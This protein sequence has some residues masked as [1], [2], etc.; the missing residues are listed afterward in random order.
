MRAH[1]AL[2]YAIPRGAD[3][4]ISEWS[5]SAVP[6]GLVDAPQSVFEL[7]ETMRSFA[8]N[9]VTRIAMTPQI[10]GFILKPPFSFVGLLFYRILANAAIST[11]DEP[12]L[13]VLS[14]KKRSK[15]WLKAGKIL[16]DVLS[17]I[18]GSESPSQSIARE[19]IKR[20][21]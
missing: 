8:E 17:Y 16:L 19:R 13:S 12:F 11:I 21:K 10:V 2:G 7:Q 15:N 3:Q 6:L 5:K 1:Q 18:L 9:E 4:Y 20:L 14:L